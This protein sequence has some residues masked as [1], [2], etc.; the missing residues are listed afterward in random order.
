MKAY[1][2]HQSTLHLY[3]YL[4]SDIG[5]YMADVTAYWGEYVT[6]SGLDVNPYEVTDTMTVTIEPPCQLTSFANN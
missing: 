5:T 1:G 4:M 3:T 6:H 2:T